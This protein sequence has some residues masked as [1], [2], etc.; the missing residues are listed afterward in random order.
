[1]REAFWTWTIWLSGLYKECWQTIQYEWEAGNVASVI[2]MCT[3]QS[4]CLDPSWIC[5]TAIASDSKVQDID[6]RGPS[7]NQVT[8]TNNN[9]A[10]MVNES[11][12][13]LE[14]NL[15]KSSRSSGSLKSRVLGTHCVS[16]ACTFV[17]IS[18][19]CGNVRIECLHAALFKRSKTVWRVMAN[20]VF[21]CCTAWLW[22]V[23]KDFRLPSYATSIWY[24]ST[25]R[26]WVVWPFHSSWVI[27]LWYRFLWHMT[28]MHFV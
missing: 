6:W 17:S 3:W 26:P 18:D 21:A 5:S 16:F 1:M 27:G 12:S 9:R 8:R 4:G 22:Q 2:A 19:I 23:P 20:R 10:H 25:G 13:L 14:P 7:A 11:V 15:Q 24:G 28:Y